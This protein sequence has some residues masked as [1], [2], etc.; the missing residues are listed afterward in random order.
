ML[1]ALPGCK[2]AQSAL[3]PAG[4]EARA[5]ADLHWLMTTGAVGIFA[6]VAILTIGAILI[7]SDERAPG[8]EWFVLGLGIAFP[9][10]VLSAL[11]WHGLSLARDLVVTGAPALR[12]EVTGE[13]WW[14]RVAYLDSKGA[15]RLADAN[16][17]HVPAG[18]TVEVVLNTADVIHSFWVPSLAGK[19][20][21]IP[22]R[23]NRF[24]IAASR[25]GIYRGQ[26]AEYCGGQHA[27]MA[28][29]VVALEPAAFEAWW[30]RSAGDAAAPVTEAE[31]RGAALF[32]VQGCGACHT[33]R[34]TEAAGTVGPDLTRLGSRTTI[35]AGTFP[36]NPGTLAGWVASAQHL[37]PGN[38]MPSYDRLE[39]R[40]LRDLAAYL[41]SLK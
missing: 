16:E 11:L 19:L 20:D 27:L 9:V 5:V 35:A 18:A 28:F 15:V 37:K 10:V 25:P 12:V 24:R 39:G 7:R 22:G 26:C 41:E 1:L 13:Q 23:T 3:D 6:L 32:Q 4:P 34:G 8:N 40:Q 14:W 36:R 31:R 33:V 29:T 30:A 21:M 2:G 38:R 17:I